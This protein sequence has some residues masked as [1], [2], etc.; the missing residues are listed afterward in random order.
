[1]RPFTYERVD[2]PRAAL[3]AFGFA[4]GPATAQAPA[5]YLAGGT[6]LIDLMKLDVM[7]P[8]G[9]ID[10]NA[11]ER[12]ASAPCLSPASIVSPG[13]PPTSRRPCSRAIS[14]SRSSF[15]PAAGRGARSI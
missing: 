14:S 12:T 8:E 6:T 9:L 15:R 10:I 5:Q 3:Q 11:L 2:S 7:R 1:M 13:M 4:E